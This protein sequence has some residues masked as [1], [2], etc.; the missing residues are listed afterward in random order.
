MLLL[1]NQ[2]GGA[3]MEVSKVLVIIQMDKAQ[4]VLDEAKENSQKPLSKDEI[5]KILERAKEAL[6]NV[7]KK[8][9]SS[10]FCHSEVLE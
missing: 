10:V 9:G 6:R 8:D 3:K 2:V 4:Q 1:F 5:Q 7:F